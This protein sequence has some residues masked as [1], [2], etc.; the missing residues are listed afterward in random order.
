[1]AR[2]F[3]VVFFDFTHQEDAPKVIV[4]SFSLA[5]WIWRLIYCTQICAKRFN[6]ILEDA[7]KTWLT[8]YGAA[9]EFRGFGCKCAPQRLHTCCKSWLF[10]A[11]TNVNVSVNVTVPTVT[12]DGGTQQTT[13]AVVAATSVAIAPP[14]AKE[15]DTVH[16]D[17]HKKEQVEESDD[18]EGKESKHNVV[19]TSPCGRYHK[20]RERVCSQPFFWL[21]GE[22]DLWAS[23][24]L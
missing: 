7:S 13:V 6:L 21:P 2:Q 19:E 24:S 5:Q 10:S 16:L 17:P 22:R 15:R 8:G 14:V 4:T 1:M 23:I 20:R 12:A 9:L 18:D 3:F 11:S